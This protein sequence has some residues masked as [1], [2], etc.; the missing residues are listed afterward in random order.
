M[1]SYKHMSVLTI[2]LWII[3]TTECK[4]KK[5]INLW[6]LSLAKPGFQALCFVHRL[7]QSYSSGCK[8]EIITYIKTGEAT[9]SKVNHIYGMTVPSD[10]WTRFLNI[11]NL[12]NILSFSLCP[13]RST[14]FMSRLSHPLEMLHFFY[15]FQF[16]IKTN[17]K[18]NKPPTIWQ[19]EHMQES[20]SN[21]CGKCWLMSGSQ[22][23]NSSVEVCW[24]YKAGKQVVPCQ[25]CL[26]RLQQRSQVSSR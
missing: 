10:F 12:H 25:G 16:Y 26:L 21:C 6:H 15:C 19:A 20:S 8:S 5:K 7:R 11:S 14:Y 9:A 24:I 3:F 17:K 2:R 18:N 13:G 1:G 23:W 22:G 4:K